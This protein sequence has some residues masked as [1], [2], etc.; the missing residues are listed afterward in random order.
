MT[1]LIALPFLAIVA[2]GV[3]GVP[4]LRE[5]FDSANRYSR[6]NRAIRLRSSLFTKRSNMASQNTVS[7]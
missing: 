5:R 3:I 2:I 1:P 4:L 7:Q 6:V